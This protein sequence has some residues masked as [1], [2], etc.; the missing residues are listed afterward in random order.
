MGLHRRLAECQPAADVRVRAAGR[1]QL[2]LG[3]DGLPR[4]R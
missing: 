4:S 1:Q 2:Q 3:R